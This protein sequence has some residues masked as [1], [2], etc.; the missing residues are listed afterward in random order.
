MVGRCT[1][2]GPG[3][4]TSEPLAAYADLQAD[5]TEIDVDRYLAD[6]E[7]VAEQTLGGAQSF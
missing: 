5:T 1:G 4:E 6:F 3:G 2:S 7:H